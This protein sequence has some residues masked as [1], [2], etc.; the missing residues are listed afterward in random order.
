MIVTIGAELQ[1]LS[2]QHENCRYQGT[3]ALETNNMNSASS[4]EWQHSQYDVGLSRLETSMWHVLLS[5]H[6]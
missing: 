2:G 3:A 6:Q 5:G 1:L 4:V